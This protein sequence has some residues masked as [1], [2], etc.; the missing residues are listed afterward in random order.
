ME[1]EGVGNTLPF[2]EREILFNPNREEGVSESG[3]FVGIYTF[4]SS[5]YYYIL[6]SQPF[7]HPPANN[8]DFSSHPELH[9]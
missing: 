7:F 3:P 5:R 4:T 2:L 8:P 1:R 6:P 9:F